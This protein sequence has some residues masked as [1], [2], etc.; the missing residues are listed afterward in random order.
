MYTKQTKHH[1]FLINKKSTYK[2]VKAFCSETGYNH[3]ILVLWKPFYKQII[4]VLNV[5]KT[6]K[7]QQRKL[8]FKQKTIN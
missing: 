1:N 6:T 8:S 3:V 2:N 7:Q 4:T 5:Q